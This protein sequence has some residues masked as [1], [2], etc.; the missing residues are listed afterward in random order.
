MDAAKA[1]P[2]S[3]V[4]TTLLALFCGCGGH[5]DPHASHGAMIHYAI[6]DT[7][8]RAV[9]QSR[10]SDAELDLFTLISEKRLSE[11]PLELLPAIIEHAGWSRE[12]N[13]YL[14]VYDFDLSHAIPREPFDDG[15]AHSYSMQIM[16]CKQCQT[17]SM[18]C[19]QTSSF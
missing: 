6:D 4:C 3:I 8:V 19:V 12:I 2:V 1:W 9:E 14:T 17:L 16:V 10:L 18:G 13:P 7:V 11:L 15:L 5:P